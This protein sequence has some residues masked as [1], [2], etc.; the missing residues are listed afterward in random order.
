M[1]CFP[2]PPEWFK[3]SSVDPLTAWDEYR[4]SLLL[5]IEFWWEDFREDERSSVW[6]VSLYTGTAALVL[7]LLLFQGDLTRESAQKM[8]SSDTPPVPDVE[9]IDSAQLRD[10]RVQIKSAANTK[11]LSNSGDP[12]SRYGSSDEGMSDVPVTVEVPKPTSE[13]SDPFRTTTTPKPMS[14]LVAGVV[15]TDFAFD[16]RYSEKPITIASQGH[17]VSPEAEKVYLTD[18]WQISNPGV[19]SDPVGNKIVSWFEREIKSETNPVA[20]FP[21]ETATLNRQKLNSA[22]V[23]IKHLPKDVVAGAVVTYELIVQ[24]NSSVV[25][26]NIV[27]EELVSDHKSVVDVVPAAQIAGDSLR[28]DIDS[29]KPGESQRLQI[30]CIASGD[31]AVLKTETQLHLTYAIDSTTSVI[32]PDVVVSLTLPVSVDQFAEFSVQ[33]KITNNSD[34]SYSNADL[35]LHL[36]KGIMKNNSKDLTSK[37]NVPAPGQSVLI[38]LTLTATELGV[39]MIEAELDLEQGVIVPVKAHLQVHTKDEQK[40]GRKTVAR[41]NLSNWRKST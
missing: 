30:T 34:R 36:L 9:L 37:I 15:G 29:L 18:G 2:Y 24:N 40:Q 19:L 11:Q 38:P 16:P 13:L 21:V 28:W 3:S 27:V 22:V 35:N 31:L 32:I 6:K 8:A 23:V 12:F 1:H 26:K 20:I 14:F 17:F 7:L 41:K 4:E 33:I 10:H 39:G 5:W 25:Q